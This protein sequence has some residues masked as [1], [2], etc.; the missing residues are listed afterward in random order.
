M[1]ILKCTQKAGKELGQ[2]QLEP[3]AAEDSTAVV[4]AWYVNLLRFGHNKTLLFTNE[5]SLYS[6]VVPYVK[7]DLADLSTLF[8]Q[9]LAT[10]LSLERVPRPTIDQLVAQYQTVQMSKTDSRHV[11][12]C[13]NDIADMFMYQLE[14]VG[15]PRSGLLPTAVW[16]INHVIQLKRDDYPYRMM[17]AS[18]AQWQEGG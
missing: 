15:G 9:H 8:T 16:E 6:M 2:R 7:K 17:L 4:G 14:R 13:M 5:T 10:N 3:I 11:L 18:L 12:G 1:L